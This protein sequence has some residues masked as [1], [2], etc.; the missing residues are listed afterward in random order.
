VIAKLFGMS[1]PQIVAA[2]G[3]LGLEQRELAASCNISTA[4][5]QRM[6]KAPGFPHGA[7]PNNVIAVRTEL[8][9][10]GIE[11]LN[12]ADGMGVM[13]RGLPTEQDGVETGHR[14]E[15]TG[16]DNAVRQARAAKKPPRAV[17]KAAAKKAPAKKAPAKKA[18]P[19]KGRRS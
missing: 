1:G 2:R 6:E 16:Q 12:E 11:F 19:R 13:R 17:K 9:Q 8:E 5:L 4:T 15:M 3:L 14:D 10:R 18:A 7:M